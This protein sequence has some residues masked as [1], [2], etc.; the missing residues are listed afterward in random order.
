[1]YGHKYPFDIRVGTRCLYIIDQPGQ[2]FIKLLND[3]PIEIIDTSIQ[4]ETESKFSGIS[5]ITVTFGFNGTLSDIE[6]VISKISISY[7]LFIVKV[8]SLSQQQ[9]DI[10]SDEINYKTVLTAQTYHFGKKIKGKRRKR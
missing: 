2:L 4:A 7:P 9:S 10:D 1:M 3:Y 5:N 6:K 8:Q